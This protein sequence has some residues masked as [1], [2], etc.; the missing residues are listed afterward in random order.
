MPDEQPSAYG[1]DEG[2][3]K[4][5]CVS[6]AAV[7]LAAGA[8]R[9]LGQ[10]KQ[11]LPYE[12]STLIDVVVSRVCAAGC[13]R[14]GVV[15]GAHADEVVRAIASRPV[16]L[17]ENPQWEEG[18]AS[19]LRAAVAWARRTSCDGLLVCVG[20]QPYL[21]TCHLQQLMSRFTTHRPVASRYRDAPDIPAI[22]G[23][24]A[25]G[26]LE[27]LRGDRGAS[28]VLSRLRAAVIEWPDGEIDIDHPSDLGRLSSEDLRTTLPGVEPARARTRPT[29]PPVGARST[30]EPPVRPTGPLPTIPFARGSGNQLAADA[31]SPPSPPPTPTPPPVATP[32]RDPDDVTR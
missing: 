28:Q 9:R 32:E 21:S 3:A 17:I 16:E 24:E 7:V 29:L 8:S 10:P 30:T 18:I 20:D 2:T 14:V 15:I 1:T 19:S 12:G 5:G 11:L 22:F 6:I 4:A 31:S 23:R 26:S 13:T 27:A 25:F